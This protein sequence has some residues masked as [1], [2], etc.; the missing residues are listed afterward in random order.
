VF[1]GQIPQ[2]GRQAGEVGAASAEEREAEERIWTEGQEPQAGD[3][4]RPQRGSR[5]RRQGSAQII[6]PE[7]VLWREVVAKEV[8]LMAHSHLT[9]YLQDHR[10]GAA[11][12]IGLLE[13][14]AAT[15][16]V[17]FRLLR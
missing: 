12:A 14:L 8:A 7:K 4:D 1:D 10:A 17:A 6:G 5:K 11:A 13:H 9:T 16:T 3:C 15:P 2:S